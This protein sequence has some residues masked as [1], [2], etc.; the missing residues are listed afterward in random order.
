MSKKYEFTGKP[1]KDRFGYTLRRIKA[2]RD[3]GNVKAGDLG[4][5]IERESNLSHEGDCWV[6]DEAVVCESAV[7]S[8]N[9][10]VKHQAEVFGEARIDGNATIGGRASVYDAAWVF[11]NARVGGDAEVY[12]NAQVSGNAQVL[13]ESTVYGNAQVFGD[14]RITWYMEIKDNAIISSDAQLKKH[15][16]LD[17]TSS[18]SVESQLVGTLE[19]KVRLVQDKLRTPSTEGFDKM[20]NEGKEPLNVGGVL[21]YPSEVFKA[22]NP[23]MYDLKFREYLEES[24]EC[25]Y[26]GGDYYKTKDL[27]ELFEALKE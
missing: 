14:A 24:G 12:G 23:F 5:W 13:D 6:S 11:G 8:E 3:F 17:D 19:E 20:L 16:R 26:V 10:V 7:V 21:I 18:V 2:L 1:K 15:L 4:G 27:V 25:V 22:V 9:A